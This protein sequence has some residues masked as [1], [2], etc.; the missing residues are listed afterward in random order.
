[1]LFLGP[2]YR[3]VFTSI[4]TLPKPG[5]SCGDVS[6]KHHG[7]RIDFIMVMISGVFIAPFIVMLL[8]ANSKSTDRP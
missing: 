1:V 7:I 4:V 5:A 6:A 8:K 3:P 2:G